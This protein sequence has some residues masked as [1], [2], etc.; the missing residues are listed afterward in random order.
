M[1]LDEIGEWETRTGRPRALSF[2]KAVK[3]TVMYFKNNVTQELIAELLD[4]SQPT[5]SRVIA[6]LETVIH[7]VLAPHVPDLAEA[8]KGRVTVVDGT[9]TP[10]W[11]WAAHNTELYSGK[12]HTTGHNHQLVCD[13]AGDLLHISDPQAGHTHDA[14]AIRDS[15]ILDILTPDQLLADKGYVGTGTVTPIKKPAGGELVKWQKECNTWINQRRYV[16]ERAIA[17]LKTWRIMHTNYRRPEHTYPAA[18][19]AIRARHFY[20]LAFE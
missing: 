8:A 11:S 20:K 2:C 5:I 19:N 9:L 16:I 10:C 14:K 18:F 17:N 4:V 13:L 1:P 7:T 3:A 12:H 6:E 15:G